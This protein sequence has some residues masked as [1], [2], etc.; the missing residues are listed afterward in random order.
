MK[1]LSF[2]HQERESWGAVKGDGIVDLGEAAGGGF[3]SL[4]AALATGALDSLRAQVEAAQPSIALDRISY[5]LPVPRPDKIL[6]VGY[7]YALQVDGMGQ[8][9]QEF[10]NIFLRVPSSLAAHGQ[11]I[12]A[13]R[14][15]AEFDYEGELAVVI[16]RRGRHIPQADALGHVAGYTVLNDGS[17]RD[18]Q[19]RASQVVPGKN[20]FA[21]GA[22]GP[23]IVTAEE[24]PD[25]SSLKLT[26]R[27]NGE[28]VQSG[29]TGEMIFSIPFLIGY[30]S[31]FTWLEPGDVIT[32]GSPGGSGATRKPPLWL[33]PG[34]DLEIE[35]SAIGT[36]RNRVEAE[37]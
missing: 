35:I 28:T 16:G 22:M 26:T 9:P 10:P 20:F 1:L 15:S 4:A 36:L 31:T 18:W 23:W 2:R 29:G 3:P 7:N 27:L 34:D 33:K 24:V 37:T 11:A 25:P 32:T 30:I 17:A 19:R 5:L 13:P 14:D 21:S 6:C 12:I 8:A